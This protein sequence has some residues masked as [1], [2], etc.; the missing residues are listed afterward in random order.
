MVSPF[1]K[2]ELTAAVSSL[3]FLDGGKY[4]KDQYCLGILT[5]IIVKYILFE[6]LYHI[7]THLVFQRP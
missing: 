6:K 5:V 4:F 1:V 7:F 3:G 2:A